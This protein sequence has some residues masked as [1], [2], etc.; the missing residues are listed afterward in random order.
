M[1]EGQR[2]RG[3]AK[4]FRPPL[5]FKN[6]SVNNVYNVHN[7]HNDPPIPSN[8]RSSLLVLFL[9]SITTL[10]S[11]LTIDDYNAPFPIQAPSPSC[12]LLIVFVSIIYPNCVYS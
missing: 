8:A 7:V 4:G 11:F 12:S 1:F 10:S 6:Y 5:G 9:A 2:R 3:R